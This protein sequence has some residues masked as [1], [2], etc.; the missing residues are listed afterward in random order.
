MPHLIKSKV[1]FFSEFLYFVN[2]YRGR[3][4]PYPP[5]TFLIPHTMTKGPCAACLRAPE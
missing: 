1:G 2:I 5:P 4:C 3:F